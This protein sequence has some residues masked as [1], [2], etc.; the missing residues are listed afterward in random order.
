MISFLPPILIL[1]ETPISQLRS[2]QAGVLRSR[3]QRQSVRSSGSHSTSSSTYWLLFGPHP[4]PPRSDRVEMEK[5]ERSVRSYLTFRMLIW[6][7]CPLIMA[8][9]R[10]QAFL[11]SRT[12]VCFLTFNSLDVG[13]NSSTGCLWPLR[14]P[15]LQLRAY[16]SLA[17]FWEAHT[18]PEE[19]SS[20]CAPPNSR[21]GAIW[22]HLIF[23]CPASSVSASHSL[24]PLDCLRP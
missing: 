23:L 7:P 22:G 19:Q 24:S 8:S 6:H 15:V 16:P 12:H 11:L 20:F 10:C 1:F 13:D 2:A 14:L 3:G 17:S 4:T 18:S 5:K 9:Y 21:R